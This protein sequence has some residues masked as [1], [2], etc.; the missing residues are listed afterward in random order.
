MKHVNLNNGHQL[1]ILNLIDLEVFRGIHVYFMNIT[2]MLVKLSQTSQFFYSY[3]LAISNDLLGLALLK[4]SHF[5]LHQLIVWLFG[6][7]CQISLSTEIHNTV[8]CISAIRHSKLRPYNAAPTWV[9]YDPTSCTS[10]MCA[11]NYYIS[12]GWGH[13]IRHD[14]I[15]YPSI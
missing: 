5:I 9:L 6:M 7:V 3:S 14:I 13:V 10:N 12:G 11:I 1:A 15:L 4:T 2:G 8:L